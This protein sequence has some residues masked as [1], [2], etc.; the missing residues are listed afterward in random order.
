MLLKRK[1]V[2]RDRSRRCLKAL[3]GEVEGGCFFFNR[4]VVLVYKP[5][6]IPSDLSPKR[7]CDP[8]RVKPFETQL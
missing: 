3:L 7:E 2:I 8:K 4:N 6:L 5:A 1:R